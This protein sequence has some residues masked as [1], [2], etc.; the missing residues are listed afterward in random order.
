VH[1]AAVRDRLSELGE[2]VVVA[3][4]AFTTP[5]TLAA[6]VDRN[7]VPFTVLVDQERDAYRAFGLERATLRRIYAPKVIWR[8]VQIH[9]A[10]GPPRQK[11]T[12]DTQQLGGNFIIDPDGTLVYGY[13]SEGPEDRPTVDDLVEVVRGITN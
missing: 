11:P 3:V 8:Y 2:K 6:Y 7:H 5:A 1:V 9:R 12:E 10:G 4:I 13:W